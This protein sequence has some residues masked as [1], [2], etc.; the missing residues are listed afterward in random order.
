MTAVSEV[1]NKAMVILDDIRLTNLLQQNPA[2]FYRKMQQYVDLAMPMVS[3]PPEL[4]E[5]ITKDYQPC[6]FAESSWTSTEQSLTEETV[7]DTGVIGF[8][9]CCVSQFSEDGTTAEL[10]NAVYNS[11]TGEV[12][13]PVQTAAGIYYEMDFCSDGEFAD[14]T[15]NQQRLMA[16][17]IAIVWDERFNHNWLNLQP[18][19]KDSAFN[20]VNEAN[21]MEK[22]TFR[23]IENRQAY[24]DELRKYEQDN[25]YDKT[26][27]STLRNYKLI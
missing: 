7:V 17:A 21:Y 4:Y 26:I 27:V 11:E 12:T 5:I 9:M 25:A 23:M 13:F 22:L 20:T 24:N 8:E 3:R 1:I 15:Q 18:K 16:L 19:I 6:T 14:L 2:L 10:Y